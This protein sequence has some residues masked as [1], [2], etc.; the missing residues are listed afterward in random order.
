[1]SLCDTID[2]LSEC[3]GRAVSAVQLQEH[4]RDDDTRRQ[5][6]QKGPPSQRWLL[7]ANGVNVAELLD[8]SEQIVLDRRLLPQGF[9]DF[10]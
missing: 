7:Q 5:R 10:A 1:M 4:K 9:A 6:C 2:C 3:L 8:S